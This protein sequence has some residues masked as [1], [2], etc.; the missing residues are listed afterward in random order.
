MKTYRIALVEDQEKDAELARSCLA[1]FAGEQNVQFNISRFANGELFLENYRSLYDIIFMDIRL[2]GIDGMETA[3]RLRQ[4]D[5]QVPLIFLTNML[6]YAIRGYEV[7]AVGYVTKPVNYYNFVMH[8][9]NAI[10]RID[11]SG[12]VSIQVRQTDG[13]IR[14]L[15]S[16]DI[17]YI[18]VMD[19]D[20]VFHTANGLLNAYGTLNEREKELAG[21]DFVRCSACALVNLRYVEGVFKDDILVSGAQVRI[22]R[23]RKKAFLSELNNYLG[24]R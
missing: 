23:N 21:Y 1:R 22:S 13:G 17:Y 6:D 14:V 11:T 20:L 15:S 9:G 5:P 3:R 18:E 24:K 8:L 10:R 7:N 16:R 12:N 19:H 2:P 4:L